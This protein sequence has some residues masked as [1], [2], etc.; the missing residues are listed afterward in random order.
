MTLG[1]AL[2]L[3]GDLGVVLASKSLPREHGEGFWAKDPHKGPKCE[4]PGAPLG[5]LWGPFG[6]F[7]F[8]F[9][10]VWYMFSDIFRIYEKGAKMEL[11]R[12]G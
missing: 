8:E 4:H 2:M 10:S 11:P 9:N 7:L 6:R 5:P 3:L 12:G 1:G